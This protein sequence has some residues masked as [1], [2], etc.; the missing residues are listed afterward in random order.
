MY[1]VE[2]ID[3][4]S[5]VLNLALLAPAMV[6]R[7]LHTRFSGSG[8]YRFLAL[9]HAVSIFWIVWDPYWLAKVRSDNRIKV[10]GREVWVVSGVA[11]R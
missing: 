3:H 1:V 9:F 6:Q 11:G 4:G 2:T 5:L 10:V 8:A 7:A